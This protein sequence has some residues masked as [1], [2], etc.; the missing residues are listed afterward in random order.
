MDGKK[1]LN[2]SLQILFFLGFLGFL[3]IFTIL[4]ILGVKKHTFFNKSLSQKRQPI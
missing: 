4:Y 3:F 2:L 1:S